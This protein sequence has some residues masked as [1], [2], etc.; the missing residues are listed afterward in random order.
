MP[1]N[2][3]T[4]TATKFLQVDEYVGIGSMTMWEM[5]IFDKALTTDE[6]TAQEAYFRNKWNV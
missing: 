5:K 4:W 3:N 6:I 2:S 1:T